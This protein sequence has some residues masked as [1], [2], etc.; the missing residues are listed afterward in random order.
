MTVIAALAA[1]L[2]LLAVIAGAL[3]FI[4]RWTR[5]KQ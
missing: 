3:W 1:L 2:V 4:D 5:E